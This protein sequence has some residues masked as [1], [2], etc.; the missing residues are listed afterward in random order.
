MCKDIWKCR[1]QVDNLPVLRHFSVDPVLRFMNGY[2][3][4]DKICKIRNH[5]LLLRCNVIE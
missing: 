3:I 4:T 5:G 2:D 1:K